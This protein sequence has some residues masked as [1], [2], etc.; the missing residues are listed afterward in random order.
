MPVAS[1]PDVFVPITGSYGIR[2]TR[3]A[4]RTEVKGG[5]N[6]YALDYDRGTCEVSVLLKLNS[7]TFQIWQLFYHNQIKKGSLPFLLP[8][9][10]GFGIYSHTCFIVPDTYNVSLSD[11]DDYTISFVV[12]TET[13]AYTYG[14]SDYETLIMLYNNYGINGDELLRRINTFANSDVNVLTITD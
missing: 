4:K 9:D 2:G 10:T 14:P 12:E 13:L 1:L 5:F 11:Y 7:T 3:G 6:R 8:L